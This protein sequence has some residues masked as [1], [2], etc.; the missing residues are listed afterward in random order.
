VK[1]TRILAVY[2]GGMRTPFWRGDPKA[3]TFMDPKEIATKIIETI[4]ETEDTELV[5]RRS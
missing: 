5:L 4:F 3:D 2:P 1:E